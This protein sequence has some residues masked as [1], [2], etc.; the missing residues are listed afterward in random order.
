MGLSE[1]A[2]GYSWN[3]DEKNFEEGL[4]AMFL[5]GL[6]EQTHMAKAFMVHVFSFSCVSVVL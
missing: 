4:N 1:K 3:E 2:L 6:L 5:V